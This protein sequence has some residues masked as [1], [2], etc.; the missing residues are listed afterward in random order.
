MTTPTNDA[1]RYARQ[2]AMPEIGDLGQRKLGKASVLIVGAGGLGSPAAW[3]LVAAGVGRVG[4]VDGDHVD[5][6]NLQRQTL[7]TT[8]SI[9]QLKVESARERLSALNPHV[10]I[11]TYAQRLT[12]DN[13]AAIVGGYD[14]MIDATDTFASKF[15]LAEVAMRC[16]LPYCH[17]GIDR[18][19]GQAITV[20]PGRTTCYRCLFDEAPSE[21]SVPVGPIGVVPGI[22][23]AVQAAEAI[24]FVLG[25]GELLTDRLLTCHV[26][27]MTL[28]T[29]ATQRN[30]MCP[31]C[32]E[33]AD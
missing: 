24:R 29:I 23:G 6:S 5:A 27:K 26:L 33:I 2:L 19:F 17:A 8:A 31:L 32:G 28:R 12:M 7:H 21:T 14:F 9:G 20:L 16:A 4:L 30:P 3:M 15:L 1:D 13:A 10:E 18:W 25:V 22:L 11:A